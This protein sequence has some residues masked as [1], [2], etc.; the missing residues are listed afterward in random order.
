[1]N[2]TFLIGNGFDLACG[3]NTSYLDFLD[4][5]LGLKSDSEN[6]KCFKD[7][8]AKDLETWADAEIAFGQYT[9]RYSLKD[10]K[11]FR[12]CFDDFI[13]E[14]G[15]YL[16]LQ[17]NRITFEKLPSN[18]F[19]SFQQ[20]LIHFDRFLSEESKDI[21]A[22]VYEENQVVERSFN[23]LSFNYT[24][25]FE[26]LFYHIYTIN[27]NYLISTLLNNKECTDYLESVIHVHGERRNPPLIFGV[28]NEEQ[29]RNK[30][31]LSLDK[32]ARSIIKPD[33]NKH[34][35]S[36]TLSLCVKTIEQSDIICVY[37]MSI[38]MTDSIW[39]TRILEWLKRD[40]QNQLIIHFY[41]PNCK[42]DSVGSYADTMDDCRDHLYSRL[43]M[44]DEDS[45]LLQDQIHIQLNVD[46][47]GV[48]ENI[49]SQIAEAPK[50]GVFNRG[51]PIKTP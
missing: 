12:E 44:S 37:G 25:V 40:R 20:G 48:H 39:W 43:L 33:G 16:G 30:D 14:L 41:A 47:F 9:D 51:V 29:I 4:C 13:F 22:K 18:V 10:V 24:K 19:T 23:V 35:R 27:E 36:K 46:L 50:F 17:E 26:E 1:M 45:V 3:L 5:Y 28:D 6:I 34:V 21:F 7:Y 38:G 15:I 49:A 42:K 31:L 11:A 32:F 2:I 8:I